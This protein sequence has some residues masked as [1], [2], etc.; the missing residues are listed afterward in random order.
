MEISGQEIR[1][2]VSRAFFST[3][4]AAETLMLSKRTINNWYSGK[5][6]PPYTTLLLLLIM[7]EGLHHLPSAGKEWQGWTFRNGALAEPGASCNQQLHAPG[8]I[9]AW[10]FVSQ[11]LAH[12]RSNENFDER[13]IEEG[14][15]I[16]KLPSSCQRQANAITH[17]MRQLMKQSEGE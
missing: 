16:L 4:N 15:N 9:R 14:H 2:L 17:Q 8:T 5:A 3:D 12:L 10:H 1:E 6:K 7:G 13:L 11:Q